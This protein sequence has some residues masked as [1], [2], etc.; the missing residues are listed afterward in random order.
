[1]I[2]RH[3]KLFLLL[4]AVLLFS[5]SLPLQAEAPTCEALLSECVEHLETTTNELENERQLRIEWMNY[6]TRLESVNENALS[7][8]TELMSKIEERDK[9]LREAGDSLDELQT[10]MTR[11][12]ASTIAISGGAGVAI[13]IIA[14]LILLN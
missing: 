14:T 6:A 7:L 13:G 5:L 2:W 3:S 4:S 11:R 12:R 1:M 9:R 8:I 10:A